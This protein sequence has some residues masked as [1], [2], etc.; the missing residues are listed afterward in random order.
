MPRNAIVQVGGPTGAAE[1]S[2]A[3]T[4]YLVQANNGSLYVIYID[5]NVDVVFRK[6][7]NGGLTW[8]GPTVIFTGSTTAISVWYDRWTSGLSTDLIHLAYQE[9]ASDDTL[10]RTIDT[11]SSDALSTQT[12]IFAGLTTAGG[13]C[14]SICRA[15][16]GNVYCATIIDAGAEGGFFRLPSANVP[17]GAWDAARTTCFEAASQDQII[18]MPGWASDNQDMMAFFW[19][20]SAD[21]I[22]RKL[23]DD[24]ANS[25]AEDVMGTGMADLVASTAFPNFSA[26]PDNANSRNVLVAW[27]G[28]DAANSDLR[29]WHVTEGAITEVTNVVENSTDDQGLTALGIDTATGNWWVFYAGKSDGSETWL[30]SLRVYCKVSKDSGATWGPETEVS[31]GTL[32][33]IFHM[34]CVPRF[35]AFCQVL[36]YLDLATI[37]ELQMI[38]DPVRPRARCLVRI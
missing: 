25:W 29:C 35:T 11:A 21:E 18:L 28:T 33:S 19:D 20:V 27:S 13:G 38:V 9:S 15:R 4:K 37:D 16:G 7:S 23:Y 2:G 8:T 34:Y 10:Y 36:M 26:A 31:D 3:G 32:R 6:S 1:F 22:S 5:G 14:L 12:S 24:S 17:N 30:T